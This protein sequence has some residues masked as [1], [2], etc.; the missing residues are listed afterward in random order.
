LH[1]AALPLAGW[2][3]R[4]GTAPALGV[5]ARLRIPR[6]PLTAQGTAH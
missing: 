5:A 1:G 4:Y 2:G 3:V 6:N